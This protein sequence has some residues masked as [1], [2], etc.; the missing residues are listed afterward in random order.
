MIPTTL[1]APDDP[2]A[3]PELGIF[4]P[5]G[6]P[7]EVMVA[8]EGTIRKKTEAPLAVS[9]ALRDRSVSRLNERPGG[10]I[11]FVRLI[12]VGWRRTTIK[13]PA[14]D[15][16]HRVVTGDAAFWPAVSISFV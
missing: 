7:G 15:G 1:I 6:M 12:V 3:F 13:T 10:A 16:V 11:R 9:L 5:I 8:D 4:W 14:S 2:A